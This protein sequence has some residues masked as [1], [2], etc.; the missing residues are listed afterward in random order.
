MGFPQD[1]A[2]AALRAANGNSDL[3]VEYLMSGI[4]DSARH[5]PIST[6]TGVGTPAASSGSG[7]GIEQLRR[8]P[9]LNELR[10]LVQQNPAALSQVLEAIG[11]QN[12]ELLR[13]IHG[14]QAEFLAMMNEP[15]TE[16]A[17]PA[18]P[19]FGGAGGDG[20]LIIPF[21]PDFSF[22]QVCLILCN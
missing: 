20:N 14:N 5:A 1:Q 19:D 9:Q 12:P 2:E 18:A 11:Q 4:P 7:S 13:L 22:P 6:P 21:L 15:I 3:A 10:R 8:H 17:P 16:E